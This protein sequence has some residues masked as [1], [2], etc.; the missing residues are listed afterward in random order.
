MR[1]QNIGSNMTEVT[2]DKYVVLVSYS[3]PVAYKDKSNGRCYRSS[4]KWSSTTSKHINKWLDG[5]KAEEVE[6][7]VLDS[8]M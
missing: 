2:T 4:K 8:I 7:S 6:Q 5:R 1:I 3:T